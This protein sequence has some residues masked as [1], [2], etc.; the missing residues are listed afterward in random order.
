[1]VE[2]KDIVFVLSLKDLG[3][4]LLECAMGVTASKASTMVLPRRSALGHETVAGGAG[5][6]IGGAIT[7]RSFGLVTEPSV[8]RE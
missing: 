8:G 6:Y 3:D 4:E 1:M 7:T 2:V 5:L